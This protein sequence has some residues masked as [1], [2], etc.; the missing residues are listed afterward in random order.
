MSNRKPLLVTGAAGNL[1]RLV[2]ERLLETKAGPIIATTR[3]PE[4]LADF[5]KRGVEVRAADYNEPE[6]LVKAFTGAAR[7]LLI[8]TGDLFPEGLR[9]KQ[10][11]AAVQAAVAAGVKHVVYTSGPA[12]HPTQPGSLIND[13]F[14]TEQALAAS[15]LEWTILRHHIYTDFLV[16]TLATALK[17][18]VLSGSAGDGGN[19]Y[20]TR[21]D[22]ARA[23][24]AAL[25][26]DFSGRRI[27]DVTG[28]GPVTGAELAGLASELAGRPLR[29][30]SVSRTEHEQMLL[31]VGLP[32]FLVEALAAFDQAQARGFL[33]IRSP[34]V[35]ELTGK[36]PTSV[37]EYLAT[38]RA[39]LTASER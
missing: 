39:A 35:L 38:Q 37:R 11:R 22:C 34:A 20:V 13:H 30:Q 36:T 7:L 32:P 33:A 24:A 15:P 5:A 8:S 27:L 31:C 17:F 12:P 28:P 1:G 21:A 18:G 9:L 3:T 2:V 25:V 19:N 14:W 26:A 23:D 4:K 6:S 16:G 29:Y 10:H